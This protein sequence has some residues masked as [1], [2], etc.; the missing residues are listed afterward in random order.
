[1]KRILRGLSLLLLFCILLAQIPAVWA[2]GTVT[3]EA[4]TEVQTT[5]AEPTEASMGDEESPTEGE[6]P[7]VEVTEAPDEAATADDAA[8]DGLL[9]VL[10]GGQSI[11]QSGNPINTNGRLTI[12]YYN[13]LDGA[14]KTAYLQAIDAKTIGSATVYCLEP[15]EHNDGTNYTQAQQNA[16]WRKLPSATREAIALVLAYGYPNQSYSA[17][18]N[19]RYW[20]GKQAMLNVEN[21]IATQLIIWELL[22]GVR[23]STKPF[24]LTGGTSY[25]NAVDGGWAT[26]HSTYDAIVQKL[27]RHN[28]IPTYTSGKQGQYVYELQYDSAA[29]EYR[30]NLPAERQSDWRECRMTLPDGIR[31][32]KAA[33]GMTVT[34]FAATE[35]AALTLPADGVTVSG[36]SPYLSVSPDTAVVCWTCSSSQTVAAM[37]VGPDPARAYFTL[38]AAVRADLTVCKISEDGNVANISFV[39]TDASGKELD[40]KTSGTDGSLRFSGLRIGQRYT[41]TELVPEGYVC[42]ENS[43]QI[44]VQAGENTVQFENRLLRGAISVHKVST[45]GKALAG[46]TFLLEFSRDGKSWAAVQPTT[47]GNNGIGTC[48]GVAADGTITTGSDGKAVFADLIIS[49]VMYRL[50]EA[51]APAGYQLLAE[52]VFVGSITPNSEQ[53]YELAYTVVN[54]PLLQMPPTGGDGALWIFGAASGLCLSL[55]LLALMPC[56][57]KNKKRQ[58][59]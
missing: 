26:V 39:L 24:A 5:E 44:T 19:D 18:P 54:A 14:W 59:H 58:E 56:L 46:A 23:S 55:A 41:V 28:A 27:A 48:S 15:E 36:Q 32:L 8:P 22:S 6:Q 4:P 7:E 52:P 57:Q 42:I 1:M 47:S 29:G 49:G 10:A 35:A 13:Y 12:G 20:Y 31:Y 50:T 16:A 30:Y 45:G 43:K 38:K 9:E 33:D 17:S 40:R 2:V 25:R 53:S 34:G 37:P 3:E 11:R 21:Y 51:K